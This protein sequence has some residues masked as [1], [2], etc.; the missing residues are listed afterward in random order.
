MPAK[1]PT[2]KKPPAKKPPTKKP[3]AKKRA[4]SAYNLF[5]KKEIPVLKKENPKLSHKEVFAKAAKNWSAQKK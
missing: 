4:P 5:M 2:A 1:K 3:A